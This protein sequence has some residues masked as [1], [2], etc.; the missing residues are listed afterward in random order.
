MIVLVSLLTFLGRGYCSFASLSVFLSLS[1][2]FTNISRRFYFL[3][4]SANPICLHTDFAHN[5]KNDNKVKR[6]KNLLK[7]RLT[8]EKKNK[9]L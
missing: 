4:S 1:K 2:L 3:F 8:L 6:P 5:M 7:E 9:L